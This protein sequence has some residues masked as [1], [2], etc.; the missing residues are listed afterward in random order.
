MS[1]IGLR[2]HRARKAKERLR[3]IDVARRITAK[4]VESFTIR[5]RACNT[6]PKIIETYVL[7]H[8]TQKLIYTGIMLHRI[9]SLLLS[10][11][12]TMNLHAKRYVIRLCWCPYQTRFCWL[13][14]APS[15]MVTTVGS[16][17]ANNLLSLASGPPINKAVAVLT[18]TDPYTP[19]NWLDCLIFSKIVCPSESYTTMI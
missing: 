2:S 10:S 18:R 14:W 13:K 8:R 16:S 9:N 4:S 11:F 3:I 12:R 6:A 1:I 17:T 7:N 15:F 5:R 19:E